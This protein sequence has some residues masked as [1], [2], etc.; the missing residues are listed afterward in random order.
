MT[1]LRK[2]EGN[3]MTDR[4]NG[5]ALG[6]KKRHGW[7]QT[8]VRDIRREHWL[9]ILMIPGIVYFIVFKYAPMGGLAIAFKNYAPNLGIFQSPWA[10][11]KHFDKF[12][13]SRDFGMLFSNTVQIALMNLVFYFP[14]P[15]IV[16][17]LLSEIRSRRYKRMIQT[18]IYLPHFLSWVVIASI[19][20]LLLSPNH[21]VIT[22]LIYSLTGIK[23]NF[24]MDPKAFKP[25]IIIEIIWR[26][27]GWGTIIFL[28]AL[29]NVDEALQEAAVIDGANRFQRIWH[30]SLPAIRATIITMLILRLGTFLDTGYEQIFLM[31]NPVTR[32]AGEVFD[33]YVY[34]K[35]ILNGNYSFSAAVGMFKSVISLAL[36]VMANSL[37]NR[38]GE[39]GIY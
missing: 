13:G 22:N 9:Y 26:E 10:G 36:V 12:F 31:I 15:I 8:L 20:F 16:S 32:K 38:V 17:I 21:G 3:A 39:E 23:T 29:T 7:F 11:L 24:L 25:L 2:E 19:A 27:A 1:A 33:T 30:I 4:G 6:A 34:T 14:M 18:F 28:A 37:A 35:G 5:L